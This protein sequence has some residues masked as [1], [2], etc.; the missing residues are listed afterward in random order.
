MHPWIYGEQSSLT[1]VDSSVRASDV[2]ERHASV[3][4]RAVTDLQSDLV[5]RIHP[6]RFQ[7]INV[8]EIVIELL[9][10]SNII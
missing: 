10:S 3:F 4:E 2:I 6:L 9:N 5:L 8:E 1:H 7:L